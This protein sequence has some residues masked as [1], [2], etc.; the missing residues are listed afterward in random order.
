MQ[1]IKIL[2]VAGIHPSKKVTN[3]DMSRIVETDDEW[4]RTRTG[5]QSRYFCED[6]ESCVSM[7]IEA[8]SKALERS[9]ISKEDIGCVICATIS[10]NYATPSVACLVQQA[11]GLPEDIPVL[12]VNAA[13]S[14]FIYALCV[15]R[16][17]LEG[18]GKKY[19]LVIGMEQLSRLLDMT[20]RTTCVL[21]GDGGGAAVIEKDEEALFRQVLGARGGKEISCLGAG[22]DE[23]FVQMDGKAVFRFAVWAMPKCIDD[24]LAINDGNSIT[25]SDIDHVVCH[26]ANSRIIDHVVKKSKEDPSKFYKNL[27]HFGNTSAGSIPLALSELYESGKLKKGN[28]LI[29]VG[30]GAGLTWGGVM[31]SF[32]GG[33]A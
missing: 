33:K 25:L 5:I 12:D 4:I 17:L 7:A 23:S 10:G 11:L 18:G 20:D 13:C 30:F 16:G 28:K 15:G 3:D 14:G 26:Q 22:N 32:E 27:D 19:G 31:I 6:G 1:G 2:S 24:L 8:S 9:G 29:L 21:F